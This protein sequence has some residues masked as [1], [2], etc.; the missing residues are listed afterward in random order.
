MP[1][2]T[3]YYTSIEN[4]G[5]FKLL[6]Y[7]TMTEFKSLR[8]LSFIL[9]RWNSIQD[10]KGVLDMLLSLKQLSLVAISSYWNSK[11]FSLYM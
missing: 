1:I 5:N 8:D 9:S 6:N 3:R 4:S 7:S 11:T 10:F 2:R